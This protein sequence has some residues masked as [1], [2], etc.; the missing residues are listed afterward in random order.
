MADGHWGSMRGTIGLKGRSP[1][2]RIRFSRCSDN[3][4]MDRAAKRRETDGSWTSWPIAVASTGDGDEATEAALEM[5][6]REEVEEEW[7]H[8][9]TRY[10]LPHLSDCSPYSDSESEVIM[11]YGWPYDGDIDQLPEYEIGI[12]D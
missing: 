9:T 4:G 12:E 3:G 8:C 6:L 2:F 7:F 11:D 1:F 10:H 5:E